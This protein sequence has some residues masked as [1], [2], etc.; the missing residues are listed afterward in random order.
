MC[1]YIFPSKNLSA[2]A[3]KNI[4]YSMQTR[5]HQPLFLGTKRYVHNSAEQICPS[6][7]AAERPRDDIIG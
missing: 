1:N 7:T 6:S 3:A 4:F 5:K 2:A